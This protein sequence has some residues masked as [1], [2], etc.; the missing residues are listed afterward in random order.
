M[1]EMEALLGRVFLAQPHHRRDVPPREAS[2]RMMAVV[3]AGFA[4]LLELMEAS[5]KH[6]MCGR[7][8]GDEEGEEDEE[9]G[10]S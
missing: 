4:L 10:K 3:G 6:M 9:G 8:E 1:I 5:P 2:S 7:E